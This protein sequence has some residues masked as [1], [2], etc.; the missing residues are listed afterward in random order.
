MGLFTGLFSLALAQVVLGGDNAVTRILGSD[1]AMWSY[2][3]TVYVERATNRQ[4]VLY[5]GDAD[6]TAFLV[7][8]NAS[9][10][11]IGV[12]RMRHAQVLDTVLP[13]PYSYAIIPFSAVREITIL[14]SV[15]NTDFVFYGRP[16]VEFELH[17]NRESCIDGEV[18][19]LND[20]ISPKLADVLTGDAVW[21]DVTATHHV[22][23]NASLCGTVFQPHE[24]IRVIIDCDSSTVL[25][26]T[27][28][29]S[30][31]L[32][33]LGV[34]RVKAGT[35]GHVCLYTPDH[36]EIDYTWAMAV[37]WGLVGILVTWVAFTQGA[38]TTSTAE[39]Q[40]MHLVTVEFVTMAYDVLFLV[41]QLYSCCCETGF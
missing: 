32:L 4:A 39:K 1:G 27:T 26:D 30:A 2:E 34:Y 28:R 10:V 8:S 22:L 38:L 23:A 33:E 31:P 21:V 19:L 40:V 9:N 29:L 17:L 20:G 12:F 7:R 13:S 6:S 14:Y 24:S 25:S 35:R 41:R 11:T 16:P 18:D 5:T 3:G 15:Y 37:V 36:K